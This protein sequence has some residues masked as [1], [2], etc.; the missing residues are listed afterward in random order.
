MTHWRAA[1]LGL[2]AVSLGSC[3]L[4]TSPGGET[5]GGAAT[6][7]GSTTTGKPYQ[8]YVTFEFDAQQNDEYTCLAAFSRSTSLTTCSGG[9]LQ[10][11]C[12]FLPAAVALA[13]LMNEPPTNV[14]AGTITLRD[15]SSTL[16]SIPFAPGNIFYDVHSISWNPGDT[17]GVTANGDAGGVDAFSGTIVAPAGFEGLSPDIIVPFELSRTSSFDLTW[18]PTSMGTVTFKIGDDAAPG[19]IFCTAPGSSGS[20][21]VPAAFLGNFPAGDQVNLELL[22]ANNAAL[23]DANATVE[24]TAQVIVQGTAKIQ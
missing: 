2:I 4:E 19:E 16:A 3:C 8:G 5:S 21:I 20:L 6:T 14:S 7:G 15:G 23:A 10:G 17:L 1:A 9:E 12:C 11:N 22:M 18:T 24:L 13:N